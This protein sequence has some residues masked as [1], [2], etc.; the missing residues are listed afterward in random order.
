[1]VVKKKGNS[2]GKQRAYQ[3]ETD[4]ENNKNNLGKE[5]PINYNEVR[6]DD[7]NKDAIRK[8]IFADFASL[9]STFTNCN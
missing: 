1:M 5:V 3:T 9:S 8:D 6:P 7:D 4:Y 2:G